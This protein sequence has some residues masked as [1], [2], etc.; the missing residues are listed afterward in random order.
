MMR[1]YG[2]LGAVLPVEVGVAEMNAQGHFFKTCYGSIHGL[3]GQL[4]LVVD[5]GYA[6]ILAVGGVDEKSEPWVVDLDHVHAKGGEAEQFFV[7]YG[8][9]G[10]DEL[11]ARR[12]RPGRVVGTPHA[13][14]DGV[15]RRYGDDDFGVGVLSHEL[16]FAGRHRPA[17]RYLGGHGGVVQ[18]SEGRRAAG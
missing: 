17:G 11:L 14:S 4:D 8:N 1:S 12:V 16:D 3:N 2:A 9:A 10:L 7:D 13:A 15:W 6:L 18:V 5:V